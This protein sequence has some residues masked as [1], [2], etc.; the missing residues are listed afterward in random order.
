MVLLIIKLTQQATTVATII[1]MEAV[2]NIIRLLASG[3]PM[4]QSEA[5]VALV[6]DPIT[7]LL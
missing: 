4:L 7:S 5:L 3:H 1:K 6:T 2:P